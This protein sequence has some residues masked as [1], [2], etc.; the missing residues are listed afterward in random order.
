MKGTI[1]NQSHRKRTSIK[2]I[3]II[4]LALLFLVS[5][6]GAEQFAYVVNGAGPEGTGGSF[7]V[8]DT[9]TNK[10]IATVP[11]NLEGPGVA[12]NPTGTKVYITNIGKN[13]VSIIDTATNK[14]VVTT[15]VG[16]GPSGVAVTPDGKKVYVA[17]GNSNTLS[18]IDAA[19]NKVVVTTKV[20]N[21]PSGVAVTPDGKKVY[22]ANGNSNTLSVIDTATNKLVATTKVGSGPSGVAV[23]PDG[24][25][26]YVAN[27]ESGSISDNGVIKD[28][29]VSVIDTVT[30]K[31]TATVT[32]GSSFYDNGPE[33]PCEV[34]VTPNGKKVYVTCDG[35]I[36]NCIVSVIDTATNKVTT[37]LNLDVYPKGVAVTPDGKKVYVPTEGHTGAGYGISIINTATNEFTYIENGFANKA[38]GQFIGPSVTSLQKPT[39]AFTASPTSG[40]IPL[41]VQF[42]D[43]ST[44]NPTSWKWD[45]GDGSATS[46]THNPLHTYIKAGSNKVTFTATNAAG[47]ST[48]TKTAYIK[49]TTP[50]KPVAAFTASPTSGTKPLKVQFTDKST[51]SPTSW[52]WNFG[53][54]TTSTTH[55][56]L[57]TYIKKGKLTVTL[58]VKNAKGSSI[59]TMTSYITVK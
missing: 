28:G 15:K 11:G 30:D 57:H 24:K 7:S 19:T 2:V 49:V 36:A 21:G 13:T 3:G 35:G 38:F 29:T 59:K 56:P 6:T 42:T 4:T 53:D 51:G 12:V 17:N 52:K 10:I 32:V 48:V 14:V 23:T 16:N 8:I 9:A 54:G 43:K 1:C 40:S 25:K 34:A 50:V 39:A 18:V 44:N 41:K 58:T 27:S 5:I 46:T 45:F 47:S 31:V 22:V 26:V 20:G 33:N 55:N 37:N